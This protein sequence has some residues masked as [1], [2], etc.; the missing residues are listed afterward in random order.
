MKVA[1]LFENEP[2]TYVNTL[3][4][5]LLLYEKVFAPNG[6]VHVVKK[7]IALGDIFKKR[8]LNLGNLTNK[9]K[10]VLLFGNPGTGEL[11]L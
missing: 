5:S 1:S 10:R 7:P 4:H 2:S 9:V 8:Q 3:D 6:Q 11:T